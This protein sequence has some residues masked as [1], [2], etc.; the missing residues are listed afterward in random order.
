V[1]VDIISIS[2][3]AVD[4]MIRKISGDKHAIGRKV[5]SGKLIIRDSVSTAAQK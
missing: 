2:E 5:I 3:T 1:E 4:A